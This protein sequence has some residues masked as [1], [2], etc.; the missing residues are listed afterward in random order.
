MP[1][2]ALKEKCLL[3]LG[4]K[5]PGTRGPGDKAWDGVCWGTQEQARREG[6]ETEA[7]GSLELLEAPL[8]T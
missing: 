6:D 8:G 2:A 5:G 3:T 4:L 1:A 7:G